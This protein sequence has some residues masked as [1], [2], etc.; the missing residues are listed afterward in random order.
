VN[1]NLITKWRETITSQCRWSEYAEE[2]IGNDYILW[3]DASNDYQGHAKILS[4]NN[5]QFSY[6]EWSYGSCSGCDSYEGLPD[7]DIRKEFKKDCMVFSDPFV[8]VNW[9][10]ML[11][12]TRDE[13]FDSICDKF[14]MSAN[15]IFD[16]WSEK[17]NTLIAKINTCALLG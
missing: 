14:F 1:E 15:L 17:P 9:M 10:N 11:K 8:F 4:Y 3:E 12:S 13:K 16:D 2:L 5:N 7:E 6:I